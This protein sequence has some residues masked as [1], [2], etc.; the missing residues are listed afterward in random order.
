MLTG[1]GISTKAGIPDFRTKGTGLYDNLQKFKLP[2]PEAIFDI[3]F[4]EVIYIISL[5]FYD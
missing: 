1:A 4:F 3:E 2:Y 5:L